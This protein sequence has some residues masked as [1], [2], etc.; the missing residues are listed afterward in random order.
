M[1]SIRIRAGAV[2]LAVLAALHVGEAIAQN[3]PLMGYVA[4]KN[5][6]PKRLEVFKQG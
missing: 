5:V 4:A 6:N 1:M 3:V 2:A